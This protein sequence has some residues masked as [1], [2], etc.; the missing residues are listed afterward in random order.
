MR[1]HTRT[2]D[3]TNSSNKQTNQAVVRG[4]GQVSLHR[5]HLLVQPLTQSKSHH[6]SSAGYFIQWQ[7]PAAIAVNPT[8]SLSLDKKTTL[9]KNVSALPNGPDQSSA[10]TTSTTAKTAKHGQPRP[11]Q[12]EGALLHPANTPTQPHPTPHP[13]LHPPPSQ[14]A[15]QQ[16]QHLIK[17][18]ISHL[19]CIAVPSQP[20]IHMPPH[21]QH[22][23][24]HVHSNTQTHTNIPTL[25]DTQ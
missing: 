5:R 8:G 14:H 16:H 12:A 25:T 22:K 17:Q 11:C 23:P 15:L 2:K 7:S 21:Q 4:C 9:H 19:V 1:T 6:S 3:T 24:Q 18:S 10:A 13:L 20:C